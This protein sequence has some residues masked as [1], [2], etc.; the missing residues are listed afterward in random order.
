MTLLVNAAEAIRDKGTITIK[1]YTENNHVTIFISDTGKGIAKNKLDKIF[2][3][4]FSQKESRVQMNVGLASSYNIIQRH[5]GEI[6]V[7]SEV[8]KGT[9]Y[10]IKLPVNL[11]K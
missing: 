5:K 2:E 8:G 4:G 10:Q 11:S 3:V 7:K 6:Q 1:T 9:R